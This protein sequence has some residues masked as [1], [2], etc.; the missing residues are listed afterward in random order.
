MNS[1][2]QSRISLADHTSIHVV[3]AGGAGMNAI[4]AVLL[5]MGHSV[6]GSDLRE[7]VGVNRLR[8]MGARVE[9]G[10]RAENIG[11][12]AVI[13]R[14]TA[15]PDSNIEIL[16][17][18]EAGRPVLS[19][20]EILEAICVNKRTVAVA[21][22]HGKTTTS[23]MLALALT[24]SNLNPSFIVGGDLNDIGSGAVWTN[25]G[26]LFVVEADESDGTF[27]RV[28]AEAAIVTN[29][30]IDHLDFFGTHDALMNA[31]R[32][33][34]DSANGPRVLCADDP[35]ALEIANQVGGCITYGT[36]KGA[37]YRIEDVKNRRYSSNFSIF[38]GQEAF[39]RCDLPIPGNHN[40]LNATA[41][42]AAAVELGAPPDVASATL[43][44][45]AGVARR[46]E[47]RGEHDGV[48]YV[49][50]YAHLPTEVSAVLAAAK[51]GDWDRIIAV[52]QPH[53]YSRTADLWRDFGDSFV[54]ADHIV[55]TGIYGA[56]ES[57]RPGI[58]G[59]LLVRSVLDTHPQ[60]SVTYLP[61]R[62]QV[63]AYLDSILRPGDLCLTM[64]AGDL[65]SIADEVQSRRRT[66]R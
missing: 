25:E 27:L 42:F 7:S 14:S 10:H 9:V 17:A 31:F 66:S 32:S 18:R 19:R 49:D 44:R 53:R 12:A 36:A 43:G 63:A 26:D 39:A 46:F 11:N 54:D 57:P 64:G 59:D 62:D 3:G 35:G 30:E 50:D 4:A 45:F 33:F 5:S 1:P 21:G 51:A 6:S 55:L 52:F 29:V 24:A 37:D 58:T 48:V 41:A 13:C 47:F 23:S 34:V 16:A 15:V 8:T 22:T 56:G 28:G 60:S 40:V 65:T 20:A 2:D 38:R 61:G